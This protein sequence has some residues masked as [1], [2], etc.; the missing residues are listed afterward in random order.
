MPT[1]T[2]LAQRRTTAAET[3]QAET[4]GTALLALTRPIDLDSLHASFDVPTIFA[5]L[6]WTADSVAIVDD[7]DGLAEERGLHYVLE[8]ALARDLLV[9]LIEA[10]GQLTASECVE[11]VTAYSVTGLAGSVEQTRWVSRCL[12]C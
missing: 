3:I 4:L 9:G 1:T 6:P 12:A 11:V 2:R 7:A 10:Q 5:E 8:V